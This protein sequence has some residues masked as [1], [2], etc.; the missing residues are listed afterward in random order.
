MEDNQKE[1][2]EE[3]KQAQPGLHLAT[4]VVQRISGPVSMYYLRPV[5]K[6]FFGK[7]AQEAPPLPLILL[8]GD[9]HRDDS[10]MC[11]PCEEKSG[12]FPLYDTTLLKEFDRLAAHYPVD[13]YT[14]YAP[15]FPK[16]QNKNILFRRFLH[17]TVKGCHNRSLRSLKAY[18]SQCPTTSIRWHYSDVRFMEDK[19]EYY[20][21]TPLQEKVNLLSRAQGAFDQVTRSPTPHPL[22][23]GILRG[24]HGLLHDA[25]PS[26]QPSCTEAK[27]D[28]L[29]L[30]V[31]IH[32]YLLSDEPLPSKIQ[33]IFRTYVQMA[34]GM[35]HSIMKQLRG[36]P[37]AKSLSQEDLTTFMATTFLKSD[38]YRK[39]M[40]TYHEMVVQLSSPIRILLQHLLSRPV[41]REMMVRGGR[42]YSIAS[43]TH[44]GIAE[45]IQGLRLATTMAFY[46][47]AFFVELYM[48]FRMLKSP[49]DNSTPYLSMGFFGN[50]HITG[51]LSLLHEFGYERAYERG[52]DDSALRCITIDKPILL[53][54]DQS[55]PFP[56]PA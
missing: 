46:L 55:N 25:S 33:S 19:M 30:Y 1:V 44:D 20:M 49:K 2:E 36:I 42:Q 47:H 50:T 8:W 3:S 12:C 32:Y 11:Q 52:R 40:T 43:L 51:M 15:V 5:R 26:C 23:T 9:T 48:L 24:I 34:Y 54:Q 17:D 6:M 38:V 13:F 16:G 4:K 37:G 56:S 18:E 31:A 28:G 29:A 7:P 10:G 41:F 14:E 27:R 53:A 35:N 22:F 45:C 39:K 21:L